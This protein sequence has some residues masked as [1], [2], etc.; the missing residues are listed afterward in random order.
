[1]TFT[2]IF[3]LNTTHYNTLLFLTP[4]HNTHTYFFLLNTYTPW[5]SH[6]LHFLRPTHYSSRLFFAQHPHTATHTH[7][8]PQHLG[9]AKLTL[10][11]PSLQMTELTNRCSKVPHLVLVCISIN[12]PGFPNT[13]IS[14]IFS[15]AS[16]NLLMIPFYSS[17]FFSLFLYVSIR[18]SQHLYPTY[19]Y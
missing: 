5:H 9:M 1:M 12:Y 11:Q 14:P 15:K 10:P 2:L 18:P 4:T 6:S 8:I 3:F 13:H 16:I 19:P 7:F 17:Y